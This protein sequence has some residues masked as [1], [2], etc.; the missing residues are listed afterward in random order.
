MYYI[1]IILIC[2]VYLNKYQ[3]SLTVLR[4]FQSIDL[5]LDNRLH[6][7]IFCKCCKTTGLKQQ[8]TNF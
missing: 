4:C 8:R 7:V 5:T 1:S 2:A 3:N 6:P